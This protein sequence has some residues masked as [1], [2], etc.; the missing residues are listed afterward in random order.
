MHHLKLI[1]IYKLT[2]AGRNKPTFFWSG[3]YRVTPYEQHMM[4]LI[5]SMGEKGFKS[6]Y[7]CVCN[8]ALLY[9]QSSWSWVLRVESINAND[10]GLGFG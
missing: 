9:K 4:S 8:I 3:V 1:K 7:V 10:D 2:K 6:V 5:S